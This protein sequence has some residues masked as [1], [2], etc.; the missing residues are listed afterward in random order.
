MESEN[1]HG[2]S[3][4]GIEKDLWMI[5]AVIQPFKLDAVT[6]ALEAI[7][8]FG[9]MTVSECRGFGKKKLSGNLRAHTNKTRG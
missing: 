6:L 2:A 1:V 8:N 4:A 9:G 5:V 3:E 7:P